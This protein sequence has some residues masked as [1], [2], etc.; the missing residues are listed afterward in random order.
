MGISS[1]IMMTVILGIFWGGFS[2]MVYRTITT[3]YED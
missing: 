1:I 2:V 3:K